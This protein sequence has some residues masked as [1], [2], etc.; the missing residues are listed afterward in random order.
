MHLFKLILFSLCTLILLSQYAHAE[1]SNKVRVGDVITIILPGEESL[2]KTFQVNKQGRII[3]PEV[4]PLAIAG[5]T[6]KQ[7]VAIITI[8]LKSVMQDLS[9]LQVFISKR[10]L[11]IN[12][13]GYVN[14]PGEYIIADTDSVQLALHAAGGLRPGAQLN[15]LQLRRGDTITTFNYKAF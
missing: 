6:E 15:R 13:Q 7:M 11:I 4:G 1:S 3:L 14:Q 8:S 10:Q 9:H 2:N 12:I 5:K